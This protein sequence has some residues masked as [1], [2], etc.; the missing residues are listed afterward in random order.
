MDSAR[1]TASRSC[2]I[3]LLT[4]ALMSVAMGSCFMAF[5]VSSSRMTPAPREVC[6]E[7]DRF[8]NRVRRGRF[9]AVGSLHLAELGHSAEDCRPGGPLAPSIS[10]IVPQVA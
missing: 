10:V 2:V 8:R 5:T 3:S 1:A 6:P 9:I 4:T 7:I